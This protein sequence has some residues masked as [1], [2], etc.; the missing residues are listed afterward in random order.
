[1][2][3][4]DRQTL[5]LKFDQVMFNI[6]VLTWERNFEVTCGIFL[7][8]SIPN[9]CSWKLFGYLSVLKISYDQK[10]KN[11]GNLGF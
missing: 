6:L 7:S 11:C 10:G 5:N 2:V 3:T 1:M 9:K 8:L 4:K